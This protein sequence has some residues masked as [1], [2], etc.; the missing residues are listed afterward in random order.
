M[1]AKSLPIGGSSTI[2]YS[3]ALCQD[4]AVVPPLS[5]L[6][7]FLPSEKATR[8]LIFS[9]Q[10]AGDKLQGR[11]VVKSVA[12]TEAAVGHCGAYTHLEGWQQRCLRTI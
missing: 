6:P 8:L 3:E 2:Q 9:T 10:Q 11:E 5:P 7:T 4:A 12:G 1:V